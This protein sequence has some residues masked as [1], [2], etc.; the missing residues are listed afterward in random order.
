VLGW[1]ADPQIAFILIGVGVLGLYMEFNN[2]GLIVPGVV[3]VISLAL[4]AWSA[5][6]LPVNLL[7]LLLIA[8]G[9]SLFVLEIKFTSHGLLTLGGA[10][11]LTLGFLTLFDSESMPDLRLSLS[12]ILPTSLTV[13]LLMAM[14]TTVAVRAQRLRVATGM[15]ALEG[16]VGEAV[17]DIAGPAGQPEVGKVFVHGE[18]WNAVSTERIAAGAKIRVTGV[19]NMTLEVKPGEH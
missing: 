17:T 6:I 13:A 8:L 5:Q 18:Y 2:P 9:V 1:I 16:E 12:F 19:K 7:G 15:E 11:S 10:L 3:G 4:F 14:V